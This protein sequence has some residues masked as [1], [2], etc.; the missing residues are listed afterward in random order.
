[1]NKRYID[2]DSY[3]RDRKLYP[4]PANFT[5]QMAQG[6]MP[7]NSLNAKTAII[8]RNTDHKTGLK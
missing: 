1:M 7:I 2:I 6:G 4:N 5:D 8:K 3:Y